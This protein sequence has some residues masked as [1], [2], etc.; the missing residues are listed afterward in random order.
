MFIEKLLN[1]YPLYMAKWLKGRILNITY[2]RYWTFPILNEK[3][4]KQ[5]SNIISNI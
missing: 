5:I 1:F 3:V 2:S 4:L